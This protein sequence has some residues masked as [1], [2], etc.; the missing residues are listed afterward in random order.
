MNIYTRLFKESD[1]EKL[2]E[3]MKLYDDLGYPTSK[4]DLKKRLTYI[5]NHADY[6]ILLLIK[7]DEIIGL[8]GMCKMLFYEKSGEYMRILAFVINSKYR[9]SGFGKILLNDSERLS[10]QLNCK[11]ITLNSGNRNERIQAHRLYSKNGFSSNTK[12]FTKKL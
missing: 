7:N 4:N 1:F 8:S 12:G 2:E 5:Y 6:Y 3:L 11:A 9:N 10:K